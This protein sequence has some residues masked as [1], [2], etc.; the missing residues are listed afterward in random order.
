[1]K[2]RKEFKKGAASFYIVAFS[3]LILLIIVASFATLIISQLTRSSNAD[4]S[5][6]AYDSALAGI[7]DAKLAFMNYK[8]CLDAGKEAK[9]QQEGSELT[10]GDIIRIMESEEERDCD[11]VSK[12]LGRTSGGDAGTAINE[13]EE[14][15]MQ[16]AYTCVKIDAHPSNYIKPLTSNNPVQVLKTKFDD[17]V[18]AK[19]IN[20]I[21]VTWGKMVENQSLS[22][23]EIS[24]NDT[25]SRFF[26]YAN[27]SE[28]GIFPAIISVTIIQTG[29][30]DFSFNSFDV[31]DADGNKTNKG[32]VYLVP[33]TNV[34]A[35]KTAAS[36]GDYLI[37]AYDGSKN[38][39]SENYVV[40]SNDKTI[41]NKPFA[42]YCS[43]EAT[44]YACSALIELPEPIG[45]ERNN[46]TFEIVTAKVEGADDTPEV[47]YCMADNA[48]DCQPLNDEDESGSNFAN[49]DGSQI[50]VDSTGRA[51]DL[52]RR[53]KA[54]LDANDSANTILSIMGP[55]ELFNNNGSAEVLKKDLT[56]IREWNF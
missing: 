23:T 28:A 38:V 51:N 47:S 16:Q 50:E 14:N 9:P 46:D 17:G 12:I 21:L 1:M 32:T 26:N 52:Y 6:S 11:M 36:D 10:C 45:G 25:N 55:L 31:A 43:T 54:R 20:Y 56:V 5:Q 19:D 18:E 40:K 8:N 39:I 2:K 13:S 53:V 3:T 15:N 37:G 24:G 41:Q 22:Y 35:A 42:V 4:L 30:A 48:E 49:L 34:D 29:G 27:Q 44:N 7:E 33:T